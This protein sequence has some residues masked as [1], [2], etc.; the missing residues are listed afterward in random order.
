MK[1]KVWFEEITPKGSPVT[2]SVMMGYC[3]KCGKKAR[4]SLVLRECSEC[5]RKR[6]KPTDWQ[7]AFPAP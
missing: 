6:L 3:S 2:S 7:D 5:R 4:L 1:G